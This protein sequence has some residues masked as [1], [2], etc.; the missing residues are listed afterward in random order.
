MTSLEIAKVLSHLSLLL[1]SLILIYFLL[2]YVKFVIT[3]TYQHGWWLIGFGTA[4]GVIYGLS[5]IF[6]VFTNDAMFG[7]FREGASLFFILFLALGI[8]SISFLGTDDEFAE[9][10]HTVW[11]DY[12]VVA[13][14]IVAWWLPFL[15]GNRGSFLWVQAIG[16]SGAL[17]LAL[18]YGVRTVYAFEGTSV[19]AVIRH[20]LPAVLCFGAIVLAEIVNLSAGGAG[21]FLEAI[22]IV[23]IVL[24]GAFLFNTAVSI[25]QQESEIHRMYD[26]TTW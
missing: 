8:R 10:P 17:V 4:A 12:L 18:V 16:W 3:E 23:G 5:G 14:F 6:E 21:A 24:V 19:S 9:D 13:I 25:K 22:W 15:T 2:F 7:L 1:S 26:R 20:L 11:L